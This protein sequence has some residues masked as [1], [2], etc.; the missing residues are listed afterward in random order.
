MNLYFESN[1]K[2]FS[3][4]NPDG[5]RFSFRRVSSRLLDCFSWIDFLKRPSFQFYPGDWLQ[6]A[7][8][9]SVGLAA[10]GLWMNILCLMHQSP[11]YGYLLA[12]DKV[13][14]KVISKVDLARIIGTTID[15][16]SALIIELEQVGVFSKDDRGCLFSRRMVRDESIR[17]SRAC[18]GIK[19]GNPALLKVNLKDNHI[20][21]LPPEDGDVEED[22]SNSSSGRGCKGKP[23]SLDEVISE[24]VAI[25]EPKST[26][27]LFWNFYESK[28]WKVGKNPM[29]KWKSSL[30]GW[31][32]RNK[33]KKNGHAT[34]KPN[35]RNFGIKG[36]EGRGAQTAW[37]VKEMQRRQDAADEVAAGLVPEN[38]GVPPVD[39]E[40]S[41]R[42][43]DIR[44]PFPE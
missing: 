3:E 23:E 14:H 28:G 5:G 35:P 6:D 32:S 42:G 33:D 13:N 21:N 11:T 26:A 29:V 15:E 36:I 1:H 22:N 18:G 4:H 38:G 25:G 43:T 30:A 44:L 12:G 24:C 17:Q 8:L 39:A 41:E 40:S 27:E 2:S 7:S 19:G 37:A 16:V 34:I 9:R 20:H 31:I 10:Q